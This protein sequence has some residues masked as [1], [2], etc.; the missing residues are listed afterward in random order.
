MLYAYLLTRSEFRLLPQPEKMTRDNKVAYALYLDMMLM[1]LQLSGFSVHANRR[2]PL[3][4]LIL[5]RN[6]NGTKMAKSL[7]ADDDI[8]SI[9]NVGNTTISL[10]DD[11]IPSLYKKI[12]DSEY[13]KEYAKIKSPE[14]TD[15]IRLWVT[16]V[17]TIFAKDPSFIAAARKLED[18]TQAGFERAINMV[19][20]TLNNYSDSKAS[21]INARN[22][23]DTSLAK[24]YELYFDIFALM[25]ELTHEQERRLQA[26]KEKYLPTAEDL[27]PNMRFVNNKFIQALLDNETFAKFI[28]KDPVNWNGDLFLIRDLLDKITASEIYRDYMERPEEPDFAAD[29]ELWRQILKAIIVPSDALSDSMEERSV[30]WNDDLDIMS[31][32]VSKTIRQWAVAGNDSPGFLP[33]YKDDEDANFGKQLFT[34]TV[35]NRELYRSYLDKYINTT[36]WDPERLAYMDIVL[37]SAIISEL[38]TFPQIPVPV[39]LNEY[40][41]MAHRYSTPKSSQFINGIIANVIKE[42]REEGNL[43]K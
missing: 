10:F 28:E 18:F 42:L 13:L 31:T 34:D 5:N 16:I 27:N 40:L 24:A 23:L 22:S 32:F 9:I 38:L 14:I 8:R 39:T 37:V 21:L 4:G 12:C 29:C 33:M 15:T 26:A 6:L 43:M 19:A 41:D 3:H 35:N 30:F 2:D 1:I 7:A 25:V 11:T 17:R 20:E 36:Q